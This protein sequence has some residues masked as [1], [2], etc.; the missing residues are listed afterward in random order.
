MRAP[1]VRHFPHGNAT[2][3]SR[4]V[5]PRAGNGSPT[6]RL[7][8]LLKEGDPTHPLCLRRVPSHALSHALSHFGFRRKSSSAKW[9]K[10]DSFAVP[11]LSRQ[12]VPTLSPDPWPGDYGGGGSTT[13]V[14]Q[15]PRIKVSR[16]TGKLLSISRAADSPSRVRFGR[17][18]AAIESIVPVPV[19]PSQCPASC[20]DRISSQIRR[21]VPVGIF[22]LYQK[23]IPTPTGVQIS[24]RRGS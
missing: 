10:W 13:L 14:G 1:I 15:P 21:A 23:R 9:L 19:V 12:T 4:R 22:S 7:S 17:V 3:G 24:S 6:L 11:K 5:L 20:P 2:P 8:C 18:K 16:P